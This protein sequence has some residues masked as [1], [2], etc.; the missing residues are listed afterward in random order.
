MTLLNNADQL[1]SMMIIPA[2]HLKVMLIEDD[3]TLAEIVMAIVALWENIELE[4]YSLFSNLPPHCFMLP[5][6]FMGFDDSLYKKDIIIL[7]NNLSHITYTGAYIA[8]KV[9]EKTPTCKILS[10]SIEAQKYGDGD[11]TQKSKLPDERAIEN[12]IFCM[13]QLIA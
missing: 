13:N 3:E 11:F 8:S 5:D 2:K 12:L 6:Y 9:R 7:D 1:R 10:F 4:T